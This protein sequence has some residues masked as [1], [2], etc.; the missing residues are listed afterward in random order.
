MVFVDATGKVCPIPVIMTKKAIEA[1]ATELT[2]VVDN[3]TAVENLKRLANAIGFDAAVEDISGGFRLSLTKNNKNV[4]EAATTATTSC[5]SSGSWA[6]FAGQDVIGSGDREL[7]SSLI[8]MFFYALSES[9]DLPS[10]ILLMNDGVKLASVNNAT[11]E[12]LQTL[13]DKGVSV[14]VCGTCL[15]FYGLADQL[16]VGMVSNMYD[17]LGQMQIAA[18][19]V[20]L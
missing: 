8:K 6:V 20:S 16:K 11:I 10:H 19:V 2:V 5:A 4:D 7:G 13:K 14:L 9:D 17:I 1:G 3:S 18:K 15:N 12:H